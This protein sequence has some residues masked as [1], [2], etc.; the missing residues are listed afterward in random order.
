MKEAFSLIYIIWFLRLFKP[1]WII[2][3]Y[4]PGTGVIRGLPT[5]FL[6]LLLLYVVFVRGQ[7]LKIDMGVFV[8]FLSIGVSMVFALNTGRARNGFFGMLDTLIFFALNAVLIKKDEEIERIFNFYMAAMA[9]YFFAGIIHMREGVGNGAVVPFHVALSDEDAFGPFMG[10][11]AAMGLL[12][13]AKDGKIRY[14][15]LAVALFC[16]LGVIA[17]YA[18]GA[19]LCL[20]A[21]SV[22]IWYRSK[23]KMLMAGTIV[24][25]A[26]FF[27]I[28]ASLFFDLS[29]Y[30][31]EIVSVRHSITD[32]SKDGR[33]FLNR[34]AVEIF[35]DSIGNS[36]IGV[37]SFNYGI[38]L[39]TVTSEQEAEEKAGRQLGQLYGRDTH[40]IYL[41]ILAEQGSLGVITFA[42][43]LG[44][45]WR[46]NNFVQRKYKLSLSQ[47]R[48]HLESKEK[49]LSRDRKYNY[50]ALALQTA[51]VTFLL[52]GLF[53]NILYYHWVWD[54]LILNYLVYEASRKTLPSE[55]PVPVRERV[56]A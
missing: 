6:Y 34:K 47:S 40:N 56:Y 42:I 16:S 26:V 20:C 9:F 32:E 29:E 53:Y 11:G 39:L 43:M 17:S 36:L 50:Y 30:W 4:V 51:M 5:L 44:L 14:S 33:H 19:F 15:Y 48:R 45:F 24:S 52:N 1:E 7:K 25:L 18:R 8:F 27:V 54:L 38:A 10:L 22:F 37:G 3:Y 41:Q 35:S 55:S 49:L 13:S 23:R 12:L 2:A 46:K 28:G 21:T 31:E